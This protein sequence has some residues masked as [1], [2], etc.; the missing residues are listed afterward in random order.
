[1]QVSVPL[2]VFSRAAASPPS[3]RYQ[4]RDHLFTRWARS[5][6][7]TVNKH[8][9]F[10]KRWTHRQEVTQRGTVYLPLGSFI[11]W[12]ASSNVSSSRTTH[13][14]IKLILKPKANVKSSQQAKLPQL[15]MQNSGDKVD[16]AVLNFNLKVQLF[17]K[18]RHRAQETVVYRSERD[19]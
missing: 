13:T 5:L 17:S 7:S 18:Q 1:M 14:H 9:K 2:V 10:K 12:S 15:G 11:S 16:N 19:F 6:P 8:V 3:A 4:I